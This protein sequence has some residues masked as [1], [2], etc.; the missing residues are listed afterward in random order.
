MR[1]ARKSWKKALAKALVLVMAL[2][3]AIAIGAPAQAS[4][5]KSIQ[6]QGYDAGSS[7]LNSTIRF[8][9]SSFVKKNPQLKVL[10]CIGF[11]DTKGQGESALG[12]TRATTACAQALASN[13][14]LTL[15]KTI[16]KFDQTQSGFNNRRV[17]LV[18]STQKDPIMTTYFNH[19]DGSKTRA[20]Y[21]ASAGNEIVLPTPTREGYQFVGWFA[22]KG[23]GALVGIG[24][25]KFVPRKN[26]TLWAR[27]S[28]GATASGGGGGASVPTI[29][30]LAS[31]NNMFVYYNPVFNY[32]SAGELGQWT[33]NIISN[34]GLAG[35]WD[36]DTGEKYEHIFSSSSWDSYSS[37]D[38]GGECKA[39]Q[40]YEDRGYISWSGYEIGSES[41]NAY[42]TGEA[43]FASLESP[44][45]IQTE[46][47]DP[48]ESINSRFPQDYYSG[49]FFATPIDSNLYAYL[50]T[51]DPNTGVVLSSVE[52]SFAKREVPRI[53]SVDASDPS[54]DLCWYGETYSQLN[55]SNGPATIDSIFNLE[56]WTFTDGSRYPAANSGVLEDL[57]VTVKTTTANYTLLLDRY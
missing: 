13:P 38:G 49:N 9:I 46:M 4:T 28:S 45:S 39:I 3:G 42:E 40:Y 36:Y 19:N 41:D 1:V 26:L 11:D 12:K 10:T 24:G 7:K 2:A 31:P 14:D 32:S 29:I 50:Y 22:K 35:F 57:T 53:L 33:T 52:Y 27:W 48:Q 34:Y 21:S 43:W 25:E 56:F 54:L 8:R 5:F 15:S 16:G 17:L 18:L 37:F 23:R 55:T 51:Y 44:V 20:S 47:T 30:D 6:V